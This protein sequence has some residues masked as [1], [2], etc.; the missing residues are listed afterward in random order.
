MIEYLD[1]NV[2]YWHWIVFGIFCMSIEML[3]PTMFFLLIGTS[4]V[5]VGVID[6]VSPM[7]FSMQVV[8]WAVL[9]LGDTVVWFKV[10][11]PI[12]KG[13]TQSGMALEQALGQ[14]GMVTRFDITRGRGIMRFTVP[15]LGQEEWI[16]LSKDKLTPGDTAKIDGLSGNSLL[17]SKSKEN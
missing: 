5:M 11:K 9:S 7:S 17:V 1:G 3:A 4:A 12:M 13:R 14:T 2:A 15:L 6:Y 10:L 16:I 8:I